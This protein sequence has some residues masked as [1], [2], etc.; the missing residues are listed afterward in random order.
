MTCCLTGLK[1]G[2]PRRQNPPLLVVTCAGV[3]VFTGLLATGGGF[4]VAFGTFFTIYRVVR[5]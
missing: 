5:D 3:C 4:L 2:T 1:A